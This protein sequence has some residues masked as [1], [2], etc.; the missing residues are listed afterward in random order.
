MNTILACIDFSDVTPRVLAETSRLAKA[1]SAS[2]TLLHVIPPASDFIML[3]PGGEL[4]STLPPTVADQQA[5]LEK[6]AAELS[7]LQIE[8]KI[9]VANGNITA[10]ILEEAASL[11]PERIILGSHGHGRLHHLLVGSVAESILRK[12]KIPVLIVPSSV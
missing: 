8:T 2:V 7:A 3:G 10:R 5:R 11:A 1:L 9:R 6:L 12:S 4:G